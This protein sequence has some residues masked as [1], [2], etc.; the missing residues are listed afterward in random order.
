MQFSVLIVREKLD[1]VLEKQQ[2]IIGH[3]LNA[4]A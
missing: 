3:V 2:L 4:R 1:G